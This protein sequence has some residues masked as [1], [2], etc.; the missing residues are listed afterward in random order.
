MLKQASIVRA[1]THSYTLTITNLGAS[2]A[3]DLVITDTLPTGY[4][5]IS[6]TPKYGTCTSSG[7]AISCTRPKLKPN[8]TE[9]I[10]IIAN[11]NGATGRNCATVSATTPDPDITNNKDCVR[12]PTAMRLLP[13]LW[14]L[15]ERWLATLQSV[16]IMR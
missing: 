7:R 3:E 13:N 8:G 4:T 9:T 14:T 16:I 10:T 2:A 12:V 15:T 11:S 5:I 1:N 6:V